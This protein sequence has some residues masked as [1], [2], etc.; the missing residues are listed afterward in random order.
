MGWLGGGGS[1]S[2]IF[3]DHISSIGVK[4]YFRTEKQLPI[5][6]VEL[7]CDNFLKYGNIQYCH[8]L[9]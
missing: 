2:P 6:E 5:V 7:G 4:N 9:L 8:L 1:D 3:H